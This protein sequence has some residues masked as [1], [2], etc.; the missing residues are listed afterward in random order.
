MARNTFTAQIEDYL[1]EII[2]TGENGNIYRCLVLRAD[3]QKIK[4][5]DAWTWV[6]DNFNLRFGTQYDKEF[7]RK[8]YS[9]LRAK[10]RSKAV[11]KKEIQNKQTAK[12]FA[13][14]RRVNNRTGGG[15]GIDPPDEDGVSIMFC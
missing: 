11:S 4:V 2:R 14:F 13:E 15:P 12:T 9:Y 3:N 7:L 5:R 10:N 6:H 1:F 8:K